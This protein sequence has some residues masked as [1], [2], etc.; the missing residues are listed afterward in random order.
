MVLIPLI[1]R[2][3]I[4][5]ASAIGIGVATAP[6]HA[7]TF[8]SSSSF[9]L[10]TTELTVENYAAYFPGTLV[11]NGSMLGSLSYT[12]NTASNMGGVITNFYNSF[13]GNS[14]AAKQVAGPLSSSDFFFPGEGFTVTFP[15]PV[16]AVGLFSNT[17]LPVSATLVT[18]SGAASTTWT[19]YD[20]ITFGFLG[21][22]SSTPFTSA[23]FTQTSLSYNIPEIEYGVAVPGSIVGAGLPGLLA[24]TVG[25]F[26]WWRRRTPR[27]MK[28]SRSALRCT[29]GHAKPL[30]AMAKAAAHCGSV[31]DAAPGAWPGCPRQRRRADLGGRQHPAYRGWRTLVELKGSKLSKRY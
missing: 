5:A 8:T 2:A 4:A 20:T 19:T 7:V 28:R 29:V 25:L 14:L 15:L 30:G 12:F 23:T 13:S 11:L 17:F 21:F 9:A 18:L 3:G 1:A 16:T 31:T 26:A 6:A 10:A 24:A 22:T 27:P